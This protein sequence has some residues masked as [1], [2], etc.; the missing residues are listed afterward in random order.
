[1]FTQ[2]SEYALRAVAWLAGHPGD[3]HTTGEIAEGTQVP[4]SYLSKVLQTLARAGIVRSQRGLGGG[5]SL[6]RTPEE[7]T[8]LDVIESVDPLPRI[9][10]CPLAVPCHEEELCSLRDGFR[11][12]QG[13][14]ATVAAISIDHPFA[15]NAW[16]EK[17]NFQFTLLSDFNKTVGPLYGA[18]HEELG[19]L[20]GVEKRAAFVIDKGGNLQY[21]WVS[22]D[23]LVLPD[24][25]EIKDVL[26]ELK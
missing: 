15:L 24:F 19:P 21:T 11:E 6:A 13:L 22:D 10:H 12:F 9:D 7:L 20:K 3:V 26:D 2:T 25:N 18:F 5:F 1:M 16:K 8:V 17:E 4:T 14:N 23:P